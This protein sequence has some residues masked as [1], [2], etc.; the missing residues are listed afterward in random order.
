MR[1]ETGTDL[2]I[3]LEDRPGTLAKAAKAIADAGI[4]IDGYA[5]FSAQGKGLFHVLTRDAAGA[6]RAL[7]RAGFSI[8]QEREV[9]IVDAGDRPGT[10]ANAL[11]QVADQEINVEISYSITKDRFV[12]GA[13][14]SARI[15]EALQAGTAASRTTGTT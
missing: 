4:N 11:K 13:K 8:Q 5:G 6:R 3:A 15:K 7:E 1:T 12:I 9:I 10:L 14:D 2:T